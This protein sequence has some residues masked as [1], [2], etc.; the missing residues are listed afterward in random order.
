MENLAIVKTKCKNCQ[1]DKYPHDYYVKNRKT[2]LQATCKQC[3]L[4]SKRIAHKKK[5]GPSGGKKWNT[6][7]N[8]GS[9]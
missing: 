1:Q 7:G 6:C 4:A 5:W 2:G 8:W 9:I 3:I